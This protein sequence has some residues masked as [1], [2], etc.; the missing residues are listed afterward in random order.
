[1][2]NL[3]PKSVTGECAVRWKDGGGGCP[4]CRSVLLSAEKMDTH[5]TPLRASG[6]MRGDDPAAEAEAETGGSENAMWEESRSETSNRTE[7]TEEGGGVHGRTV[8]VKMTVA[9]YM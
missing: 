7:R 8:E 1:M 4:F 2:S 5:C 3:L 6:P 9:E